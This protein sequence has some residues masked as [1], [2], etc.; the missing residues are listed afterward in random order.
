[1]VE[2][3][4]VAETV[5][6]SVGRGGLS[7]SGKVVVRNGGPR[8]G[9]AYSIRSSGNVCDRS[10]ASSSARWNT[11]VVA[12]GW[13]TQLAPNALPRTRHSVGGNPSNSPEMYPAAKASPLPVPST[14]STG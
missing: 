4:G 13:R 1:M 8:V 11:P 3:A 5:K 14:Y 2:H 6:R 12:P 10:Q 9:A 7:T